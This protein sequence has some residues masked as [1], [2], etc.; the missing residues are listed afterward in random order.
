M[1]AGLHQLRTPVKAKAGE[2]P[3]SDPTASTIAASRAKSELEAAFCVGNLNTYN[4]GVFANSCGKFKRENQFKYL[5]Q[6]K[7]RACSKRIQS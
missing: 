3:L 4:N 7:F 5:P 2:M 1:L 6:V